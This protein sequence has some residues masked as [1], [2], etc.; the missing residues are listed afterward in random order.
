MMRTKIDQISIDNPCSKMPWKNMSTAEQG[1]FCDI[2]SK[3]VIDFTV[4]K[5]PEIID[6]LNSQD[7]N[8]CAKLST[9][10]LNRVLKIKQNSKIKYWKTIAAS[11]LIIT[12]TSQAK[13]SP[14]KIEVNL[15][16][17]K[18]N[19]HFDKPPS[20]IKQDSTSY[21]ITG[22]V[23]DKYDR[24]PIITHVFVEELDIKITTDSLG[25]FKIQIPKTIQIDQITLI[26]YAIGMEDDFRKKIK[27][28]DLPVTE[29]IIE[30]E[31]DTLGTVVITR[32][33]RWWEFWKW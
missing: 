11:F 31:P 21:L 20:N 6:Y 3:N 27:V 8:I 7:D 10:Q 13:T 33:K 4:M 23:I 18:S 19:L 16:N 12:A 26:V 15:S 22:K 28:I 14:D 24:D 29:L 17:Y 25:S 30:R 1:K 2:C 32:K 9:S 5:D